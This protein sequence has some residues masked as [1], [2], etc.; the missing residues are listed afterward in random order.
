MNK[1]LIFCLFLSSFVS[2]QIAITE[3]SSNDPNPRTK[4]IELYNFTDTD[5]S[6][7]GWYLQNYIG[8]SFYFP[9]SAI[10][11]SQ[12]FLV[13]AYRESNQ[14]DNYFP[15]LFPTVA[16]KTGKI[17]YQSN[18]IL[19]YHKE[20]V[21][22]KTNN[23]NNQLTPDLTNFHLQYTCMDRA[24]HEKYFP[25]L[26][27]IDVGGLPENENS[28]KFPY[29]TFE[30]AT[31]NYNYWDGDTPILENSDPLSVTS[32]AKKP[33]TR[34]LYDSV[35]ETLYKNYSINKFING[36]DYF[37]KSTCYEYIPLLEQTP[38]EV[39]DQGIRC[40]AYDE[41]GNNINSTTCS[42]STV[43]PPPTTNLFDE[44]TLNEIF[45]NI[46]I[47]P[48][49]LVNPVEE[50]KVLFKGTALGKISSVQVIPAD[51]SVAFPVISTISTTS[52]VKINLGG[53]ANGVYVVRITLTTGQALTKSLIKI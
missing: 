16:G 23:I 5:I 12:E 7:N 49:P 39:Y 6:L 13:V 2:A 17:Y 10:L 53:K 50:F 52:E 47:A 8:A 30:I 24:I 11:K 3:I 40:F 45:V 9:A 28:Y 15:I 33:A 31:N 19:N 14:T 27:N 34:K 37:I 18:I 32:S 41:A 38:K 29:Q 21:K 51:L 1:L 22:L 48:N 26:Q 43:A 25:V 46:E 44:A 42:S 36:I 20:T 4:F 35:Y